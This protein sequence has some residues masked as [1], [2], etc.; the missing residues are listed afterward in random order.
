MARKLSYGEIFSRQYEEDG[1]FDECW[2]Q[3]EISYKDAKEIAGRYWRRIPCAGEYWVSNHGE[4]V[5]V[6]KRKMLK[7]TSTARGGYLQVDLPFDEDD[8]IDEETGEIIRY[9]NTDYHKVYVSQL[10]AAAFRCNL[11]NKSQVHHIDE[12]QKMNN[13]VLNLVWVTPTENLN[14]GTRSKRAGETLRKYA[15]NRR[16]EKQAEE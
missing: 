5:N 4:V 10:V 6:A 15:A 11:Y 2:E 8:V 13:N 12:F 9:R 1:V 16:K 7:P 3:N 14:L